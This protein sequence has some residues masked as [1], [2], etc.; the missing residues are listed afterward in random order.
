MY[1]FV[2]NFFFV[3]VKN[4]T[5]FQIIKEVDVALERSLRAEVVDLIESNESELE[6]DDKNNLKGL[7]NLLFG[8]IKTDF[9]YKHMYE[10]N[11]DCWVRRV[12]NIRI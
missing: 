7:Q 10:P 5:N 12:T 9:T 3:K 4:K 1:H 11:N 8:A 6:L 2:W